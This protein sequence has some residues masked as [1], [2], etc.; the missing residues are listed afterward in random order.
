MT[1]PRKVDIKKYF[2][3]LPCDSILNTD[4]FYGP[5]IFDTS[6]DQCFVGSASFL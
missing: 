1:T 2:E 3:D 4:N 5:E 6:G